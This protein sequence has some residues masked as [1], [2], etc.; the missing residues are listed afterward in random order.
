MKKLFIASLFIFSAMTA[1]MKDIQV[2]EPD[3][4]ELYAS[5]ENDTGTKTILDQDNNIRWSAGD[6]VAAFMKSSLGLKYQIKDAYVGK[7]AGYFSKVQTTSSDELGAGGEINH[8]VVYYPYSDDLC[9][10]KS[11]SDYTLEINLPSTQHYTQS[12]FENK[13]FPMIAVSDDNDITFRN[14]CGGIKLQLKGTQQVKSI[15]IDGKNSEKLSGAAVVTAYTDGSKPS[16]AMSPAAST[17][18]IMDCG[19]GIWLNEEKAVEF[20]LVAPPVVFE[21]GFTITIAT[22]D[23]NETIIGT[24]KRNEVRR[25]GLLVMPDISLNTAGTE[26]L[27]YI[28]EYGINHG[29]GI[30][31]GETVWAPVNC[32]YHKEYFKLGKYYQWG[33]KYG[34]GYFAGFNSDGSISENSDAI[35]PVIIDNKGKTSLYEGQAEKNKNVF[36]ANNSTS[37]DYGDW[38]ERWWGPRVNDLWPTNY[39]PCPEGW[40]PPA[41]KNLIE[42]AQYGSQSGVD[43][44]GFGG[45]WFC[46]TKTYSEANARLFLPYAG[47]INAT[48]GWG[49]Y[50]TQYGYYWSITYNGYKISC[51]SMYYTSEP[52]IYEYRERAYGQSLRCIRE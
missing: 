26:E 52:K 51:L 27:C 45:R 50:K 14:V 2:T 4:P 9:I 13:V 37:Y 46:D 15:K 21:K 43:S 8:T 44:E 38:Y 41:E 34:Q 19:E 20:I 30:K 35:I 6:Q 39:N 11:G 1:C 7:T 5:I 49:S 32:G 17:S 23:D 16:I 18:I 25:S 22:S 12:T 48:T 36:Y 28:D 24:D 42:L 29:P 40:R 10:E 47:C 31:I 33:R 3:V